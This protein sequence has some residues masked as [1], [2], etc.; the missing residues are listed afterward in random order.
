[1]GTV[2]GRRRSPLDRVGLL[3]EAILRDEQ[4]RVSTIHRLR[5]LHERALSLFVHQQAA[6]VVVKHLVIQQVLLISYVYISGVVARLLH[7]LLHHVVCGEL[8]NTCCCCG[9]TLLPL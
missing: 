4:G 7:Q 2:A 3:V 5:V 6:V 9:F 8:A 1:V